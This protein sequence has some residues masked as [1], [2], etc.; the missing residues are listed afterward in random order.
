MKVD[1]TLARDRIGELDAPPGIESLRLD[2]GVRCSH[3]KATHVGKS[4]PTANDQHIL[5]AQWRDGA[6]IAVG[7][8]LFQC[9]DTTSTA[10]GGFAR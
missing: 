9:P 6:G 1:M 5:A 8:G 10:R 7:F 4:L 3:G 2:I